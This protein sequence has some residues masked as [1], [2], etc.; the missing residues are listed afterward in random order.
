MSDEQIEQIKQEISKKISDIE[1]YYKEIETHTI[2][3]N[4]KMT[5]IVV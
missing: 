2:Q 4:E 1:D 3:V 5:T